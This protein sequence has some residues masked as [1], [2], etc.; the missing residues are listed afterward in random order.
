MIY[1]DC[2]VYENDKG[3][4]AVL[5]RTDD[6]RVETFLI[7][8]SN[9]DD[10]SINFDKRLIDFYSAN[11]NASYREWDKL[12]ADCGYEVSI[13]GNQYPAAKDPEHRYHDEIMEHYDEPVE[14]F[15]ITYVPKG[16]LVRISIETVRDEYGEYDGERQIVLAYSKEDF[17]E[18]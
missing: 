13:F 3:E 18:T 14:G 8:D 11:P 5:T 7:N 12:L 6:N 15:E 9:P 4:T 17:I 10:V 2:E 1:A 16:M